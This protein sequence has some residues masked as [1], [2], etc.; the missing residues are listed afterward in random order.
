MDNTQDL[1]Q[2]W[3]KS[4]FPSTKLTTY[5]S[6]Y[7]DLFSH[8]RNTDSVFIETGVLGGGSLF[9]WRNWLGP[10]ARIIGIDLNP[11][12]MKW[13]EHG[14]EIYIGD[15]G[16]PQFWKK[17]LTTI[18][19][20]DALL[21]DGGHQSFQQIVTLEEAVRYAPNK[22]V[23]AIEDTHTSFMNDFKAHGDLSFLNYAKASSDLLT[24]KGH[25]MYPNRMS[26][27]INSESINLFSKVYS[28]QFFNSLV[29]YKIDS[30]LSSVPST[31]W[32]NNNHAMPSDF[33][34]E[35]VNSAKTTWPDPYSIQIVD[36]LGGK[37]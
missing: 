22:C 2:A 14:F 15:Q 13:K 9:M 36:I 33:R 3:E 12:A 23:L 6:A 35:G 19:H 29:A 16:D 31:K 7:A 34:Y 8:L 18:G 11:Q 32:N 30:L 1:I 5:F 25:S 37:L 10:K 20:Y 27:A 4:P 17:T 21:D 28:I 24:A 26:A